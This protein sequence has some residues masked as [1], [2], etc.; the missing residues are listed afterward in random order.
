MDWWLQKR[1]KV[2][3]VL[4][5]KVQTKQKMLIQEKENLVQME[6]MAR[7]VQAAERSKTNFLFNMFYDI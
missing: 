2:I 4:F 5:M 3:I 6:Q 1:F 7:K